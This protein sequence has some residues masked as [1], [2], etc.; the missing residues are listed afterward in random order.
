M[1]SCIKMSFKAGHLLQKQ[2]NHVCCPAFPKILFFSP[3]AIGEKIIGKNSNE[4]CFIP[5]GPSSNFSS[6]LSWIFFTMPPINSFSIYQEAFTV[7]TQ[8]VDTKFP[9][10]YVQNQKQANTIFHSSVPSPFHPSSAPPISDPCYKSET[11]QK[12]V[13]DRQKS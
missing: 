2:Q 3:M 10:H 8:S 11:D 4:A 1:L 13:W 5:P 7:V 12:L 6:Y 9:F